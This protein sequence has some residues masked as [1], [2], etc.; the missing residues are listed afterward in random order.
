LFLFFGNSFRNN[1]H[2]Q[3]L[4]LFEALLPPAIKER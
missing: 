1:S 4:D 2:L 3:Y